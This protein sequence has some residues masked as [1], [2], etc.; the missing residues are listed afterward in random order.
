M[1]TFTITFHGPFHV[2]TGMSENGL[3][4]TV[5]HT[6]LL[7][8][9]GLKGLMRAAASE[10]L[11]LVNELVDDIFGFGTRS[12]R[13]PDGV[14]STSSPWWWSTPT[15]ASPAV[16][17]TATRIRVDETTGATDRG[18]LMIGEHVWADS[19]TFTVEPRVR[20]ER[21][22]LHELVL[23]AAARAVTSLGGQ[24]R[25]GEGWVTIRDELDWS[26]ADSRTL[27]SHIKGAA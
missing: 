11:E 25:R 7:P 20:M 16:V 4:R 23:R 12:N 3:D 1:I 17:S 18:F 9:S 8:S 22:A 13:R 24:R 14:D 27:L 10:E 15:F 5:D 26:G 19:A 6:N 21:R 2:S